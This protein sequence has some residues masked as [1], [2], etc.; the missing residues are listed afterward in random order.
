MEFKVGDMVTYSTFNTTQMYSRDAIFT[1]FYSNGSILTLRHH[2]TLKP[3]RMA[4]VP[5]QIR[6]VTD[7]EKILFGESSQT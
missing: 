1:V 4:V 7:A 3:V 6:L 5:K 2:K